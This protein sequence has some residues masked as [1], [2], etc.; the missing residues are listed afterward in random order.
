MFHESRTYILN[1]LEGFNSC[2]H[3][4][5]GG[6]VWIKAFFKDKLVTTETPLIIKQPPKHCKTGSKKYFT[7]NINWIWWLSGTGEKY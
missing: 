2:C 5:S 4:A 7:I 3:A 1:G 6:E